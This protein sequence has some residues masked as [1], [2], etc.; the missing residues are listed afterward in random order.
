MTATESS[1]SSSAADSTQARGGPTSSDGVEAHPVTVYEP[2]RTGLPPMR[3]YLRTVWARRPFIW[4]DARSD[5]KAENYNTVL[6]QVWLI[7]SP[8]LLAGVF[9]IGRSVLRPLG[10]PSERNYLVAHLIGG[11]FFY[12]YVIGG[13]N[14]GGRSIV[15]NRLMLM[16]SSFPR[17][18]F[19]L[20]A[21]LRSF[22]E[23]IPLLAAL[24]VARVIL[25]QPFSPSALVW[26][27]V[28]VAEVT[29]FALGMGLGTAA[30]MVFFRDFGN[31]VTLI[32]RLWLWMSPI[33]YT[34]EEIPPNLKPYFVLNPLYPFLA[35]LEQIWQGRRPSMGYVLW[36]GGWA[37]FS[38]LVGSVIFLIR[39]RDFA[40][41]L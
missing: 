37:L 11:I 34:T 12:Q 25:Q 40:F 23:F 38:L 15:A 19:P 8:L 16:N 22:F 7:L 4:H 39:E 10:D 29:L 33:L 24:F 41:R 21:M 20:S 13:W 18:V 1:A 6:G 14:L 17:A 30:I 35:A 27:P 31:V 9:I 36:G 28:V 5:L 2:S 26:I 3:A 32:S